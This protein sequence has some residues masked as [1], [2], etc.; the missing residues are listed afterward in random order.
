[1]SNAAARAGETAGGEFLFFDFTVTVVLKWAA[2]RPAGRLSY[3]PNF[4]PGT[5]R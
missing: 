3:P 5:G 1:M 4:S 2:Q